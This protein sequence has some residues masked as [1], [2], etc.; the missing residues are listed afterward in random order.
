MASQQIQQQE[1]QASSIGEHFARHYYSVMQSNK[2]ML[3]SLYHDFTTLTFEDSVVE[4]KRAI[5]E[6]IM[7]LP[8]KTVQYIITTCDSQIIKGYENDT[9]VVVTVMGRLKADDDPP[10]DFVQTF[11]L[12]FLNG[13]YVISNETFRLVIHNG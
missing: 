9:A 3:E 13:T 7:S 10:K 8:F 12:R 4:G 2:A 1:S 6:K 5:M 11:V